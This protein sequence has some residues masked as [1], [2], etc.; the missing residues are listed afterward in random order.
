MC[1]RDRG[2]VDT[3]MSHDIIQLLSEIND[4]GTTLL[5]VTHEHE[6]VRQFNK[7]LIVIYHGRVKSDTK[8]P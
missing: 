4:M 7:R 6:L 2:N 1:I 8:N 5:V 3:E